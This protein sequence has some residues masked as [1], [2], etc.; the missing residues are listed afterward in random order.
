MLEIASLSC[1]HR[2]AVASE[3]V[4]RLS[5]SSSKGGWYRRGFQPDQTITMTYKQDQEAACRH[6]SEVEGFRELLDWGRTMAFRQ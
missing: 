5:A 1:Q 6:C 3:S 4:R 2:V